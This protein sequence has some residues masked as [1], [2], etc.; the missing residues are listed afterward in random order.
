M[1]G[2][3]RGEAVFARKLTGGRVEVLSEMRREIASHNFGDIVGNERDPLMQAVAQRSGEKALADFGLQIIDV[4]LL[5]R[6]GR[7][8]DVTTGVTEIPEILH[9]HRNADAIHVPSLPQ[10]LRTRRKSMISLGFG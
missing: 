9:H 2:L 4:R 5:C 10:K 7:F 6:G 8:D 3:A 1:G